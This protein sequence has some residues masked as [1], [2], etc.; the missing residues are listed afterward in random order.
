ML[1]PQ[2]LE[3]GSRVL[4]ALAHPIRLGVLQELAD[5][6]RTV[7]ELYEQLGCSQPQ[8]S[9]QLRILENAGLV[10]SRRAGSC[11]YYGIRNPDFLQV[12]QC[13][14]KHLSQYIRVPD[15]PEAAAG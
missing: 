10:R 8:M 12:F 7:S 4:H 9:Q 15:A 1:T 5:G 14:S 13:L 6:D 2:E 11:K 3:A